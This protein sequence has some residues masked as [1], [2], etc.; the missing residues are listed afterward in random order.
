MQCWLCVCL[1]MGLQATLEVCSRLCSH[2]PDHMIVEA[3]HELADATSSAWHACTEVHWKCLR[4]YICT[5]KFSTD[6][7]D[8]FETCSCKRV[9]THRCVHARYGASGMHSSLTCHANPSHLLVLDLIF[10]Y[11]QQVCTDGRPGRLLLQTATPASACLGN[12]AASSCMFKPL[13]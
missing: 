6:I 4:T 1:G 9:Q 10:Q 3:L 12:H 11:G 8:C 13:C 5:W 2:W 7:D